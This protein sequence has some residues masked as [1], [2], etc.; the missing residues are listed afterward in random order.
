MFAEQLRAACGLDE[1]VGDLHGRI[2]K[3]LG[4]SMRD[5]K[6]MSLASLRALVRKVDPKLADEISQTIQGGHH[7]RGRAR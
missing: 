4:W 1:A 5:V 6:S 7:I 3:A 2:A